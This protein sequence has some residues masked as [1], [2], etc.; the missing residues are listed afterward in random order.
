VFFAKQFKD[1]LVA[2]MLAGGVICTASSA[3]IAD[4]QV[5]GLVLCYVSTLFITKW[6]S[7]PIA[8][9]PVIP[10]SQALVPIVFTLMIAYFTREL[11]KLRENAMKAEP[12]IEEDVREVAT[13]V[14]SA[15]R[16]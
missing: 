15:M 4:E 1:T 6:W 12:E 16:T 3:L 10:V 8:A 14:G 7:L 13:A 9:L 11:F 5:L 2:G